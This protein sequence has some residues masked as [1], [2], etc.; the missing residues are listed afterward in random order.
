M[1]SITSITPST[2]DS[3]RSVTLAGS[4]FG[5]VQGTVLIG[6]VSQTVTSWSDTSI[7]FTTSRSS[8]SMGSCRVNVQKAATLSGGNAA[9]GWSAASLADGNTLTITTNGTYSF[10]STGP[11]LV[12]YDDYSTSSVGS[13]ASTTPMLGRGTV[14]ANSDGAPYV[15]SCTGMPY[16]RGIAIGAEGSAGQNSTDYRQLIVVDTA[17][18]TEFFESFYHCYPQANQDNAQTYLNSTSTWQVKGIWH[19]FSSNG[20]SA[21]DDSDV[22]AATQLYFS[23]GGYYTAGEMVGSNSSPTSSATVFNGPSGLRGATNIPYLRTD[24]LLRQ[25]WVKCAALGSQPTGTDGMYRVLDSVNGVT[26]EA[27]FANVAYWDDSGAAQAGFDRFTLPG[28]A[29]G[30]LRNAAA[31]MYFGQVYQAVGAGSAARVEIGD[32]ASY[33]S[34]KKLSICTVDSWGNSS[35]TA[36]I[37]TGV[38]HTSGVSSLWFYIHDANNDLIATGQLS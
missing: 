18:H 16:G 21:A 15:E 27:D 32:N 3:G 5:S 24:P 14:T 36:K 34:A 20:Y 2:F 33:A 12:Y 1:P 38:F 29:R 17:R 35:I 10:G 25:M 23:S 30:Y 13:P 22:I 31:H 19:Y 26:R 37:R 7:T 4:G 6:G 8:Q 9:L 11:T 28:Y